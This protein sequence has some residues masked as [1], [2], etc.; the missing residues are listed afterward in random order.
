M[1]L[2]NVCSCFFFKHMFV[3]WE[4]IRVLWTYLRCEDSYLQSTFSE[5]FCSSRNRPRV[6]VS[7]RDSQQGEKQNLQNLIS[8]RCNLCSPIPFFTCTVL[9]QWII[10]RRCFPTTAWSVRLDFLLRFPLDVPYFSSVTLSCI[11]F[12][13]FFFFFNTWCKKSCVVYVGNMYFLCDGEK[14]CN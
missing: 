10:E 13:F 5:H 14:V 3:Q 11:L 4:N 9:A 2:K 7:G 8:A 6:P 1:F 12:F